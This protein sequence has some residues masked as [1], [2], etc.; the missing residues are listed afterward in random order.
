M[1]SKK[2]SK[3]RTLKSIDQANPRPFGRVDF[4]EKKKEGREGTKEGD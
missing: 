3:A 2:I 4:Q 1:Q